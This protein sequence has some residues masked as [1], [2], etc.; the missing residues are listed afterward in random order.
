MIARYH[1]SADPDVADDASAAIV[2]EIEKPFENHNG[3]QLA[4]GPDGMLYVSLGDGG[5]RGDPGNRAQ[6]PTVLLGKILR[7]DVDHAD[8]GQAYAIPPDNPVRRCRRVRVA[9]SGPSGCAI[10]GG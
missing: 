1:V 9:R 4:F 6:N 8:P 3:G 5:R 7:I 10:R 2:L